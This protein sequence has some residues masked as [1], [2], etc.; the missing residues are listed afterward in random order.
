MSKHPPVLEMPVWIEATV[1]PLGRYRSND[2][3]SLE[4]LSAKTLP[5]VVEIAIEGGRYGASAVV[6]IEE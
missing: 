2:D 1:V 4:L 6:I 5:R 3:P